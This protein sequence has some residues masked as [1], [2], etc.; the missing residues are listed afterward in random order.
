MAMFLRLQCLHRRHAM[1]LRDRRSRLLLPCR[2]GRG[3]SM[4]G[5]S[6]IS[7]R[8]GPSTRP[9]AR[10]CGAWSVVA[11]SSRL[12]RWSGGV[13]YIGFLDNPAV[14]AYNASSMGRSCGLDTFGTT[15]V[16]R[17]L[18]A[19]AN[20]VVYIGDDTLR[21]ESCG[22]S[23]P[24][25]ERRNG[26]RRWEPAL[27]PAAADG[28]HALCSAGNLVRAM[29]AS[30]S[31]VLWHTTVVPAPNAPVISNGP[32]VPRG[33]NDIR[34]QP[35]MAAPEVGRQHS[36]GGKPSRD[37]EA[38]QSARRCAFPTTAMDPRRW[39]T[40]KADRNAD[41]GDR[42][43]AADESREQQPGEEQRQRPG[44]WRASTSRSRV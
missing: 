2:L 8:C 4:S 40:E 36:P 12:R 42:G 31:T 3:T 30:T 22:H 24:R 15:S 19:V 21:V 26:A 28:R 16:F 39:R 32:C 34:L 7:A 18:L 14:G 25:P 27:D 11:R 5:R 43:D 35:V 23:P 10:R 44:R 17:T 37:Q 38:R 29:N 41:K 1:D 6:K 20:G 33:M 13:A 9:P